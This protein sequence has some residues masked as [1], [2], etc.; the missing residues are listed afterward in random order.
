[1]NNPGAAGL[2]LADCMAV[3]EPALHMSKG[4]WRQTCAR[5]LN[6]VELPPDTTT[7]R[8]DGKPPVKHAH[9]R[10]EIPRGASALADN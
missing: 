1:L 10:N 9:H 8:A 2:T 6:G 4:E 3:W 7:A 5:T